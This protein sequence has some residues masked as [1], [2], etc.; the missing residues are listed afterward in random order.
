MHLTLDKVVLQRQSND[1]FVT[2]TANLAQQ[3]LTET[4]MRRP[5]Q[6]DTGGTLVFPCW[7]MSYHMPRYTE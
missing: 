4:H 1:Q 7:Y 5:D 2:P 6:W 3:V